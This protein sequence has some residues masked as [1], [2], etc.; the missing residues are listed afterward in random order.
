MGYQ[1]GEQ[2][3]AS[4]AVTDINNDG[5][6][7]II[8]GAPYH[9]DYSKSEIKYEVGAVYVYYQTIKGTFQPGG[10]DELILKGQTAGGQFGYAVTA[11]GDANNDGYKDVAVGAPHEKFGN[12]YIYYGSR[13]GLRSEPGQ[14]ISGN[15]FSPAKTSFGFSFSS[16][17][18]D[19]NKY[20]DL[21]VGAFESSSIVYLPARPVVKMSSELTF[22]PEYV[23]L[24]RQDCDLPSS[25]TKVSC[26][27]LKY[28]LT[29]RGEGVPAS[30]TVTVSI[31]LDVKQTKV[32][33]LLFLDTNEPKLVQTLSLR[34]NSP[35][36]QEKTVYVKPDIRDKLSPMEVALMTALVEPANPPPL[37]PILDIYEYN[38]KATNA[39]SIF[40]DCGLDLVCIPDLHLT[41]IM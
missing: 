37:S 6:D 11:I 12:V 24:E 38:G 3:G 25:G 39:L 18:L 40:K 17:D 14:I 13:N 7:D 41:T 30:L 8:I 10:V 33:R 34:Y 9:T 4:L 27:K 23:T 15:S 1:S 28:C 36:C 5:R 32:G 29:Y 35:Q 21:I 16:Y 31:A 20:D 19:G 22:N 26:S 2:F